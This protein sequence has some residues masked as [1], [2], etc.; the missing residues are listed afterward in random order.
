MLDDPD[1]IFAKEILG[2]TRCMGPSI[3]LEKP[4]SVL[5]ELSI[6][7]VNK[8]ILKA[9]HLGLSSDCFSFIKPIDA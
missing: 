3:V 7:I 1:L 5:T 2:K 9:V 4:P 6:H 8:I